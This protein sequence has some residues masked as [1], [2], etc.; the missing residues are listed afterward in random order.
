M[1]EKTVIKINGTVKSLVFS[2]EESGYTVLRLATEDGGEITAVGRMPFVG[3]GE[4]LFA[5]GVFETHRSYGEQFSVSSFE[6]QMPS[7]AR[8]ILDYLS[9]GTVPG[10]GPKTAGRMVEKFGAGI[11]DVMAESPEKLTSIKGITREKAD[12][13]C[14]HFKRRTAMRALVDFLMAHRLPERLSFRLYRIFG[15]ESVERLKANPFILTTEQFG[16]SFSEADRLFHELGY[17]ADDDEARLSAGIKYELLFNI[18]NGHAFIPADKLIAAAADLMS[19]DE[20]EV[21]SCLGM[22]TETGELVCERLFN[23]EAVYLPGMYHAE[24]RIAERFSRLA[25]SECQTGKNI[26]DIIITAERMAGISYTELQREAI[27]LAISSGITVLTGGPGTGKT[28]TLRAIWN[29]F[30]LSGIKTALCAPTGRA[31]KRL[32]EVCAHEAKTI[33]RLLETIL[34]S[35][36]GTSTFIR[37]RENPLEFDAVIVDE[38]SMVDYELMNGLIDAMKPKC[39]LILVGD[40]DQLPPIGAG[41]VMR[42]LV[43]SDF[44]P[45]VRLTRIFRQAQDSRIVRNAHM[46]NSGEMPDLSINGGDFYFI[47]RRDPAGAARA[48]AEMYCSRIPAKFSIPPEAIQVISPSRVGSSGTGELNRI[49]QQ[50]VNPP[51]AGKNEKSWGA[52]VFREGDRVIQTRN[53]YDMA[54]KKID[55]PECG[56]GIYNGDIGYIERID[57]AAEEVSIRFDDRRAVYPFELLSE[58]EPAFAVTVHKAQGSEFEA[59]V[60]VLSSVPPR[61][62]ARNLIYTA[63]TRAKRLLVVAGYEE[64]V[65]RM[66]SGDR[67]GKRYAA[68]KTRL[69]QEFLK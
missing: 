29:A 23:V 48:A 15:E 1:N 8:G 11:F 54:F 20:E 33:H 40:A 65:A 25:R 55:S 27:R 28:T 57:H 2:N 69:R 51:S 59:V 4:Q 26:A 14:A 60:L 56:L 43:E 44:M 61:L 64:T 30:E 3:V 10:V 53:N 24:T 63:V 19:V 52:F 21:S 45:A 50:A 35:E 41:N 39:R 32:G 34:S 9:S 12:Q 42:D 17:F 47:R 66:V 31:A 22:L 36:D 67:A 62:T 46:I 18:Q 13:I 37:R 6:H 49:L 5:E 7:T 16:L 58:L 38:A 68:L